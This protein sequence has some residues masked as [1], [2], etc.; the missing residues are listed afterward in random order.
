MYQWQENV[1]TS[2]KDE[3]GG[4]TT[5]TKT[6]SYEKVWSSNE[7]ESKDFK[8]KKY[9]NPSSFPVKSARYY[10]E[11]GDLGDFKLTSQQI[12]KNQITQ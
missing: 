7:I 10:A 3:L 4:G 6:Y 8:Q 12:N 5:E 11:T 2:S 9:V 1:K